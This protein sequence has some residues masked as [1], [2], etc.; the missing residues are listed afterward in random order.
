MAD[1]MTV[2]QRRKRTQDRQGIALIAFSIALYAGW[3]YSQVT[4]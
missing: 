4:L 3:V 1:D 2:R